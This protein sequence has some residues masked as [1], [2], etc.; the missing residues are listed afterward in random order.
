VTTVLPPL[1]PAELADA[2]RGPLLWL[3]RLLRQQR[4]DT[5]VPIGQLAALGTVFQHGPLSAGEL[6]ELER[7]QPPSMTKTIAAMEERGLVSRTAHPTDRRQVVIS[8]TPAGRDLVLSTRVARTQWLARQLATLSANE[9][10]TLRAAVP[11]LEKL[12][13]R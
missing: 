12:A 11:I 3:T 6:A 2:L 4:S 10:A 8:V 5:S 9:R 13:S 7:V 1:R